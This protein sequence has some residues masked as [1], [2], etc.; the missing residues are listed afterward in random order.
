MDNIATINELKNSGVVTESQAPFSEKLSH[1][2]DTRVYASY[3][4]N[5]ASNETRY[6]DAG[7]Q[8]D[9]WTLYI[10]DRSDSVNVSVS[11]GTSI[12]SVPVTLYTDDVVKIPGISP[13]LTLRNNTTVSTLVYIYACR[14]IPVFDPGLTRGESIPINPADA[15]PNTSVEAQGIYVWNGATWDRAKSVGGSIYQRRNRG[16]IT[17]SQITLVAN[18]VTS[19]VTYDDNYFDTVIANMD[20][21]NIVYI[22]G[23]NTVTTANGFPVRSNSSERI[24]NNVY[25]LFAISA[26][27][28]DVRIRRTRYI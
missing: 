28:S 15:M 26:G 3:S 24:E 10:P 1:D 14:N 21:T 6:I 20:P 17:V 23:V 4:L 11:P 19:I 12:T 18:T 9:Y 5:L 27:A 2:V 8:P 25:E 13:I 7:I 22:S 16:G